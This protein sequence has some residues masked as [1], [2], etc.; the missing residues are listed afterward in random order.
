MNAEASRLAEEARKLAE[1]LRT[2]VV[3]HTKV[4]LEWE[5]YATVKRT[6]GPS[7]EAIY[8]ADL[9]DKLA[10]MIPAGD[11]TE[12]ARDAKRYRWLRDEAVRSEISPS[13]WCVFGESYEISCPTEGVKLDAAID[14]AMSAPTPQQE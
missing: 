9:L 8:T 5:E 6:R 14:S 4:S 10:S 7:Q 1:K 13:P 3:F 2:P 11:L 12:E